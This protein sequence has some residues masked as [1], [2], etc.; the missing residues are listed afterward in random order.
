MPPLRERLDDI[1]LLVNFY[2][3]PISK[4][5]TKREFSLEISQKQ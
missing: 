1:P 2:I 4:V 5:Q 3:E